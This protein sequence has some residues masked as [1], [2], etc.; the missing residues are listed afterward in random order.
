MEKH[1]EEEKAPGKFWGGQ[2]VAKSKKEMLAADCERAID[3]PKT[4][5]DIENVPLTLP[6]G[7]SWYEVDIDDPEEVCFSLLAF[8]MVL[9]SSSR[10]SIVC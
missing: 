8:V 10:P 4:V 5:D 2:P 3:E 9:T 1:K 7:F 6:A